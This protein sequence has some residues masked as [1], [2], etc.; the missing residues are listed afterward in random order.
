[1][2]A[3]HETV[4]SG[5]ERGSTAPHRWLQRH[6]A[7]D[8]QNERLPVAVPRSVEA[9]LR[10]P[11]QP[12]DTG[13]RTFLELRLAHDFSRV[14]VHA[15][16]PAAASALA[17]Q[18]RAYTVGNDV[19][20]GRGEYAPHNPEGR[21]L[22]AHELAHVV[23]QQG[24]PATSR[25]ELAPTDSASEREAETMARTAVAE[26]SH[27]IAPPQERAPVTTGS[28]P[29]TIQRSMLGSILG[30]VLAVAGGI[31]GALLG[32]AIGGPVGLIAGGVLGAGLGGAVGLGIGALSGENVGT[33]SRSL[34]EAEKNYARPIFH[35]TVDYDKITITR[36]SVYATGAP[37]TIRNTIHLLTSWSHF[38]GD[39]LELTE[40]GRFTLIHEMGHVWQFQN[41]GLA[42]I[43]SS[44]IPQ[45][46]AWIT[47]G[48]RNK[49]YQWTE[50]HKTGLPWNKWNAEQQAQAIEEYNKLLRKLS[51]KPGSNP[52]QSALSVEE[53]S[54]LCVLTTYMENVWKRR[55][56]PGNR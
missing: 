28:S 6:T 26:R 18:A 29:R 33:R 34:T 16:A 10:S 52:F 9:V 48:D 14:R 25:L 45:A 47:G 44:L 30:G 4:K 15:D 1:M 19:V 7:Y 55:G 43:P 13:T 5:P 46:V 40:K 42:Y 54:E 38:Q 37:R 3:I 31:G 50:A 35:D 21:Q 32:L 11:G 20:F 22:L 39:T 51:P 2:K 49:A 56:G 12:L 41:G 17:V 23:Q 27:P 8:A 24:A 36:D 53:L